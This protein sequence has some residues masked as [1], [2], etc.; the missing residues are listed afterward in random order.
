MLFPGLSFKDTC[1]SET[2]DTESITKTKLK[3]LKVSD[4]KTMKQKPKL[5]H[6]PS[7]T[8]PLKSASTNSQKKSTINSVLST[9]NLATAKSPNVG[10][11]NSKTNDSKQHKFGDQNFRIR[12]KRGRPRKKSYMLDTYGFEI[13]KQE[14][15]DFND[16]G[17]KLTTKIGISTEGYVCDKYGPNLGQ[18]EKRKFGEK[19]LKKKLSSPHSTPTKVPKEEVKPLTWYKN[20][21]LEKLQVDGSCG[22]SY[23]S[24]PWPKWCPR[25]LKLEINPTKSKPKSC[26]LSA[27]LR[28]RKMSGSSTDSDEEDI[29]FHV[30]RGSVITIKYLVLTFAAGQ[31]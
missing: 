14:Q 19:F 1:D 16:G 11:E 9:L 6:N 31:Q 21:S 13:R 18:P 23:L 30:G 22:L 12:A 4:M 15:H 26:K 17:F 25:N 10:E 2:S 7:V 3:K 20:Y 24:L 28:K 29:Q 5:S 8:K 27:N